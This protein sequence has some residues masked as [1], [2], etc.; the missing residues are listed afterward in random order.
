MGLLASAVQHRCFAVLGDS[1]KQQPDQFTKAGLLSILK[2]EGTQAVFEVF[3]SHSDEIVREPANALV[4]ASNDFT[5]VQ[6]MSVVHRGVESWFV[7]YHPEYNLD[8]YARLI[9]SR[10]E[11][12]VSM[13]FFQ[14]KSQVDAY[15][16]DLITLHNNP[17]RKDLSWK[18][19]I[20]S[21]L[22]STDVKEAEPRNWIRYLLSLR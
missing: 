19:G 6:A 9:S 14:N 15:C 22:I 2:H 5:R 13:N 12:M 16:E 4:L 20:S 17:L 1:Y 8:Y 11:R 10:H 21:D 18:Y 3:E 7:Q